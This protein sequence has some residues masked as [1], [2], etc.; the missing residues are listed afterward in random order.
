MKYKIQTQFNGL[1]CC[2]LNAQPIYFKKYGRLLVLTWPIRC[3]VSYVTLK[4]VET[5]YFILY[6]CVC[7]CV[8]ILAPLSK[9]GIKRE[10]N[11]CVCV[12]RCKHTH[13]HTR[14]KDYFSSFATKLVSRTNVRSALNDYQTDK[15]LWHL[16]DFY[17]IVHFAL[18]CCFLTYIPVCV[19]A[20][21]LCRVNP[22]WTFILV[23]IIIVHKMFY[24]TFG[25]AIS[26]ACQFIQT[27]KRQIQHWNNHSFV[28]VCLHE[29]P[30]KNEN[31]W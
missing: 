16:S 15:S 6:V 3:K 31:V 21:Y 8:T 1:T 7:V 4:L 28:F 5:K 12:G 24:S 9:M 2:L 11:D 10:A 26:T 20:I 19:C 22:S 25:L 23:L 18:Y 14:S 13:T 17:T 29:L 27:F 30:I